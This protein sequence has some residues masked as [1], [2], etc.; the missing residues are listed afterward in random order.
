[1]SKINPWDYCQ[2]LLVSQINY[3]QTYF[4]EHSDKYSHDQINRMLRKKKLT[5]RELR[6]AVREDV[7]PSENGY[8]LF[9]DTV[10]DKNHS[11]SIENVRRQWSG[12]VKKVIKGIGVVT[13]VYVNPEIERFWVIDYRIYDP[14]RDGRSKID[15]LLSMW[16]TILHVEQWSFQTVLMDSWYTTVRIMKIIEKAKK[17]YY[18]VVKAN[19]NVTTSPDDTYHRVDELGWSEDQLQ[20]G[21]LVHLKKFPKGHQ[22]KLFRIALSTQRTDYVI[23]NDK[24]QNSADAVRKT[25]AI[26]WKIEQFHREAKQVTGIESCQCRK[27]RAQ[28]N[29]IACAMLVWV[30]LTQLAQSAQS[31]VYQ[32]K[33]GLLD[34]YMRQQLRRPSLSMLPA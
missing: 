20:T 33:Q 24:T 6:D 22:L 7:I 3:T 29:H 23:T 16:D 5:P 30:R 14:I 19:R 27:Q 15:H 28:R 12:N 18:G 8:I 9:D 26:R 13:C 2:F 32:L 21:R 4:A 31:N 1:M 10:V 34:D 25:C 11:F 17:I